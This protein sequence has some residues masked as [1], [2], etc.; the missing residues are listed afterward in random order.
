MEREGEEIAL[1]EREGGRR[2][3]KERESEDGEGDGVR[4]RARRSH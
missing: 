4:E 2:G 1:R 3:D